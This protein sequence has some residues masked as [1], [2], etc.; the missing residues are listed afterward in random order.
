M[1]SVL[2]LIFPKLG[3]IFVF[4][5]KRTANLFKKTKDQWIKNANSTGISPETA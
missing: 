5:R 1:F 3:F 4:L 2:E